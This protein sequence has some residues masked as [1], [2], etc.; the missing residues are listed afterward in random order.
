[1]T[2]PLHIK[3]K[4]TDNTNST[5]NRER[6]QVLHSKNWMQS[7]TRRRVKTGHLP[8]SRDPSGDCKISGERTHFGKFMTGVTRQKTGELTCPKKTLLEKLSSF[9]KQQ[10]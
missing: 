2:N 8:N 10:K 6:F 5:K 4:R 7:M 1:M 3:L 9:R